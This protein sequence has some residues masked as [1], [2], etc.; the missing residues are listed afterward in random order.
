MSI[1]KKEDIL[2]EMNKEGTVLCNDCFSDLKDSDGFTP[3]EEDSKLLEDNVL[4]CDEC[5]ERIN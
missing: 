2:A 4:V 1:F 5:E 3:I